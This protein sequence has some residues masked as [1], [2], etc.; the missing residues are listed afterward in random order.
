MKANTFHR[1]RRLVPHLPAL[2]V[3][4]LFFIT[5]FGRFLFRGQFLIGGDAF[6]YLHPLRTVAFN[7]IR[8]G[9]LPLWTPLLMS[10]YPLLAM[11]SVGIAYPLNWTHLFLPD[12]WALQ[13][14]VLAPFILAP[15]FTYAYVRTIGLTRTA[16]LLAGLSFTYGGLMTNTYGMNGIPANALMWLPLLLLV[17]ERSFSNSFIRSLIAATLIYSLS[18]LTGHG[19]GFLQIGT[20]ALFY[21]FFLVITNKL[22][23]KR[24]W[25]EWQK[26]RPFFLMAFAIMLACGVTAFQI[27]ETMR[28]ARRSIRATLSAEELGAGGFTFV[29]ALRSFAAPLFHYLEVTTYQAPLILGLAVCAVVLSRRLPDGRDPRIWFWVFV[30]GVSFVLLLGGNTPAYKL[31]VHVPIINLVRRP[32]RYVFELTF[33]I[34][35]LAAYG[36]DALNKYT[37]SWLNQAPKEKRFGKVIGALGFLVGIVLAIWWWRSV[38]HGAS[39]SAYLG[40]KLAFTLITTATI[41]WCLFKPSPHGRVATLMVI[42]VCFVE[43]FILIGHWW[44]G[45]AKP[46]SRFN[47]PSLTTSWLQQFSPVEQRVYVRAN[48]PEEESA[49]QPRVDALN[50]TA[51]FGLHNV[52]G[53]EPFLFERYSR[54]LGNVEFD[55]V[56]PRAG[57]AA[58]NDLFEARSHV[59]DVLN[60]GYVVTW[61]NLAAVPDSKVTDAGARFAESELGLVVEPGGIAKVPAAASNGDT[62]LLVTSLAHSTGVKQET[63]VARVRVRTVEGRTI[64]SVIRAGIETAEWAHERADVQ[65]SIQHQLA[66]VFDRRNGDAAGS[67]SALRYL[68]RIPLGARTG[69]SII[70]IENVSSQVEIAVWK[71]TIYDSLAGHS[72]PLTKNQTTVDPN[73]WQLVKELDGV[74]VLRNLRTL[75]RAWLVTE[76]KAVDGEEALRRISSDADF[77]PRRTALLEV[78]PHELPELTPTV[79]VSKPMTARLV[80]YEPTQLTITTNAES[81]AVLVVSEMFYPGWEATIDGERTSIMLADYL[82]RAVYVPGGQHQIQMR[83]RA[84]AARNGAIISILTLVLL[85]GLFIHNRWTSRTQ[86]NQNEQKKNAN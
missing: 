23:N 35:V 47:T 55:A 22:S 73:R 63:V 18:I 68:A 52:A 16:A 80:T 62:L 81:P 24:N 34:S 78:A 36:W 6:F 28:A 75:P 10:G 4:L 15:V 11:S 66:P 41:I 82:L 49:T 30:A 25:L 1:L 79:L 71:L 57:F 54:A 31:L 59:L 5:S 39:Q 29:G 67:F 64:Q 86:S 2:S 20:L 74:Q 38:E 48:G 56:G 44:P 50:R 61:P 65:T 45:T 46:A 26:W 14:Y 33:A 7:M 69:I 13:I 21:A 27:F 37:S 76:V 3:V 9:E 83:Y 40:W 43:P 8:S 72:N 19:Q 60:T 85:F 51:L 77:D 42:F 17:I 58:S 84:T 53:Y 70:E 12:H 32:S